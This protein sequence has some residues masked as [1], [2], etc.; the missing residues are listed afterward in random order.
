MHLLW[1]VLLF[2]LMAAPASADRYLTFQDGLAEYDRGNAEAAVATYRRLAENGD[3]ESQAELGLMFHIGDAVAQDHAAAA[4]WFRR[5]AEQGLAAAQYNLGILYAN[6]HGVARDDVRALKWFALAESVARD[7]EERDLA[8][9][10]RTGIAQ[11][12]ASADVAAA[13]GLAC[14]WWRENA[15][16]MAVPIP[17]PPDCTEDK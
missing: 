6:G 3:A 7:E 4:T 15:W 10:N 13:H 1:P 14:D 16:M 2:S 9:A 12:M 17:A 8:N 5:A 11:R